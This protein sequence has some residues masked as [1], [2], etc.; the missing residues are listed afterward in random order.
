[1][2]DRWTIVD[3]LETG[4]T[5]VG[6]VF[7]TL[8]GVGIL[9]LMLL[10]VVDVSL[11]ET[12]GR[13]VGGVTEASEV[14]LVIV[15][16]LGMTAAQMSRAHISTPMVL[17]RLPSRVGHALRAFSLL[18]AG[19]FVVWMTYRTLLTGL[20]SYARGEFRYGIVNVPIWPARLVI[21]VGL[22]GLA[23]ALI[24]HAGVEVRKYV[25]NEP[26]MAPDYEALP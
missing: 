4:I 21:P 5:R 7:A 3:R 16:F 11:R 22:A 24:V 26:N 20:D 12:R 14:G 10:T 2:R 13:G 25:R 15:V 8:A 6:M 9:V 18:L 1:M 17:S 19:V 23:I